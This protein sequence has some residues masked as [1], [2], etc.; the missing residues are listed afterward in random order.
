MRIAIFISIATVTCSLL[1]CSCNNQEL[2]KS[3]QTNDSLL[4]VIQERGTEINNFISSFNEVETTL[5][6]V[7]AK[8]QIIHMSMDK[9]HGE[10]KSTQKERINAEIEAINS[11]M[12]QNRNTISELTRKLKNSRGK[13]EKLE[14]TI[15]TLNG[16]LTQKYIELTNLNDELNLL[17]MQVAKLQTSVDTLTAQNLDQFQT[18]ANKNLTLHTAYYIIGKSKELQEEKLIDKQGGLLGIGR[19]S[20]LNSDID[21]SKF[22]RIDYTQTTSIPISNKNIKIITNHPADS[23]VLNKDMTANNELVTNLVITNPERFWSI[24][25]Y[26]VVVSN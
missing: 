21:N 8:Q 14:K 17:N 3:K 4:A 7:A 5:D 1:F 2:A 23:Y 9:S 24:S 19:T 10:F 12:E 6:S 15:A 13:N 20:K 18:I 16:Q 25:K 11:L 26:L 22:I